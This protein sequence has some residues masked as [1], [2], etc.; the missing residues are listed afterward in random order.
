MHL[1]TCGARGLSAS[2]EIFG[3]SFEGEN[4]EA[5]NMFASMSPLEPGERN[6]KGEGTVIDPD[7]AGENAPSY[8]YGSGELTQSIGS[9]PS[10]DK[11]QQNA[12]SGYLSALNGHCLGL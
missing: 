4:V 8:P 6:K 9:Y 3:R 2:G 11:E 5:L 1:F 12:I 10:H 7:P